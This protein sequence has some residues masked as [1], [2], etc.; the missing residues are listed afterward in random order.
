MQ[1]LRTGTSCLPVV[2]ATARHAETAHIDL[3]PADEPLPM[4]SED[5]AQLLPEQRTLY[6]DYMLQCRHPEGP[7]DDSPTGRQRQSDISSLISQLARKGQY[8]ALNELLLRIAPLSAISLDLNDFPVRQLHAFFDTLAGSQ[9]VIHD[10]QLALPQQGGMPVTERMSLLAQHIERSP[11]LRRIKC[12]N[13]DDDS[14]SILLNSVTTHGGIEAIILATSRPLAAAACE[15][16]RNALSDSAH[17][18]E[19]GLLALQV[20]P[21]Y[22]LRLLSALAA[23]SR[24]Q[25]L[26]LRFRMLHDEASL[27]ELTRLIAGS[28]SLKTLKFGTLI[29]SA[30]AIMSGLDEAARRDTRQANR[31]CRAFAEGVAMC[32]SLTHVEYCSSQA[33]DEGTLLLIGAARR[34]P[35]LT[36]LY[37]PVLQCQPPDVLEAL[38]DLLDVNT[39]VAAINTPD[40]P[41]FCYRSLPAAEDFIAHHVSNVLHESYFDIDGRKRD[42]YRRLTERYRRARSMIIERLAR[43]HALQRGQWAARFSQAFFPGPGAPAGPDHLGDPGFVLTE[44]LLRQSSGLK[45]F[46]KTMVE[47][48]LCVGETAR[49]NDTS[50]EALTTNSPNVALVNS[51]VDQQPPDSSD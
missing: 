32:E 26:Q 13:L 21:T 46:A 43:N 16:L 31:L 27:H 12:R 22:E 37:V 36:S 30:S 19:V 23:S 20:A 44:H 11:S 6:L 29:P 3:P 50:A 10:L 25:K 34:N 41:F 39:A 51:S 42:G 33:A 2:P 45:A 48:A 1:N 28:S 4:T 49:T 17:L 35:G 14:A 38:A 24:L 40:D 8:R 7:F 5:Y 18:T 47:I 15:A 9:P